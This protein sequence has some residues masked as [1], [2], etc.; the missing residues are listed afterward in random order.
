[1]MALAQAQLGT[2]TAAIYTSSGNSSTVV[3]FFCNTTASAVTIDVYA[4]PNAG[5][6]SATTQVISEVSINAKDTYIM[7][8]EKFILANG[9]SIHAKAS[10]GTAITATVSYIGL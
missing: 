3:I 6:A 9:D 8:L 5:A 10:A 1:M 7:N 4:V 2:G